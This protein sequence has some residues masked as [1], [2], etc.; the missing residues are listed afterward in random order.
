MLVTVVRAFSQAT[1]RM[2]WMMQEHGG[3]CNSGRTD[4]A[5]NNN[6]FSMHVSNDGTM[7]ISNKER[8]ISIT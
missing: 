2:G 7:Y 5:S 3:A 6:K 1:R 4:G 8:V